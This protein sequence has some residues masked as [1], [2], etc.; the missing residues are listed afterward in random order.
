MG[1]N[2]DGYI[3]TVSNI[4]DVLEFFGKVIAFTRWY[5]RDRYLHVAIGNGTF[6][7]RFLSVFLK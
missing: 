7:R 2:E 6:V 4:D 1:N 3:I 5:R